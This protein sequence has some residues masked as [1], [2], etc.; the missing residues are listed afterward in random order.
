MK[1][2]LWGWRSAH[3]LQKNTM[4]TQGYAKLLFLQEFFAGSEVPQG[5]EQT[6]EPGIQN[7]RRGALHVKSI[8]QCPNIKGS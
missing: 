1:C 7:G 6:L 5:L 3:A 2:G 8:S 4:A